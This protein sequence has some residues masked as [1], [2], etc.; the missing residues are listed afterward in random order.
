MSMAMNNKTLT[1]KQLIHKLTVGLFAMFKASRLRIAF[2]LYLSLIS[3]VFT[4]PASAEQQTKSYS[5]SSI[6]AALVY[7]IL[8]FIEWQT[9]ALTILKLVLIILNFL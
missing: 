4:T 1:I 2:L 6:K 8:H 5:E 9:N 3:V 7:N